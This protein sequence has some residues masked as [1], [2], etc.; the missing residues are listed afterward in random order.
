MV[1][2]VASLLALVACSS[3]PKPAA[4]PPVAPPPPPQA[5]PTTPPPAPAQVFADTDQ[6]YAFL[7]PDR[8][9]KLDA[10]LGTLDAAIDEEMKKQALPGLAIGVVIDG[11][12]AYAKGFGVVDLA[13]KAKPDAD[14]VYRIGSIS[15]SFTGLAI[16]ALRDDG[17]LQLDDPLARWI[18]EAASLVYPSRDARPI[19]LRQVLSH[20]SGLTRMGPFDPDHGPDE[21]TVVKS[22]AKLPLESAPGTLHSYSN[23]GFSLL[24]IVAAHAAR[25]PF[26]DFL[27]SRVFGPLGMTSTYWDAADVPK[28]KLAPA[29]QNAPGEPKPA[30]PIRLG[31]ADGAGGIYSTVRDLARYAALQLSAYPPRSAPDD[32]PVRRATLREA[33]STGVLINGS[34]RQRVVPKPGEPLVDLRADSYGFGWVSGRTCQLDDVVWHGGAIDSYRADRS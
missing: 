3:S 17:A 21:A 20:T 30:E 31:A 7:D 8:R 1:A 12:L 19:T 32:G 23:L 33:H 25:R 26:H 16:L 13:T 27:A 34:A 24:G 15:K 29:F 18:P 28:G 14:T 6:N 22:L 4:P 9:T 5:R 10:A 2:R 11:E